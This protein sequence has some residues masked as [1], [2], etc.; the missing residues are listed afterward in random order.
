MHSSYSEFFCIA[1]CTNKSLF[2]HKKDESIL[3]KNRV[4]VPWIRAMNICMVLVAPLTYF[5]N[6][7]ELLSVSTSG[8]VATF[9]V[10]WIIDFVHSC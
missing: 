1:I 3:I 6:F 9:I 5:T 8:A 4:I 2:S 7:D 10:A